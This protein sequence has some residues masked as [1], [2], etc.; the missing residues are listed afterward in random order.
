[1]YTDMFDHL[2]LPFPFP[3]AL[4]EF[5]VA[6]SG[7]SAESG[8]FS[9]ASV[10]AVTKSGTNSSTATPSTSC[11]TSGSTEPCGAW[12]GGR[13]F[14][15]IFERYFFVYVEFFFRGFWVFFFCV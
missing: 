12:G 14:F 11:V 3:D 2:N 1:M 9:G 6:T 13:F 8:V 4:Q 15:C 5:G 10:N 7:L